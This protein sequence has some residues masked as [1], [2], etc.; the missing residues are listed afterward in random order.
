MRWILQA[1]AVILGFATTVSIAASSQNFVGRWEISAKEFGQDSFFIPINEGRLS[2]AFKDSR[3]TGTYNQLRFTGDLQKDGLHLNCSD[4]GAACGE[5][6]LNIANDQLTG[7]GTI[8]GLPVTV[9]GRRPADRPYNAPKHY[10]FEPKEFQS[11]FSNAIPPVLYIFPGD[12]VQTKTVDNRGQDE[13]GDPRSPRGNPQTGPFYVEGA[14]PGDTLVVH[15]D[16][17]RTNRNSAFQTNSVWADALESGYLQ[18]MPKAANGSNL[19]KLDDTSGTA[20]LSQPSD[21]LKNFVIRMEPMLGCIGVA[22]P[23]DQ[24]WGTSYLGVWG[25]NMDSREVREGSTLY[26]PVFQPGALLYLGDAHAQQGDGEITGQGL[27]TSMDVRFTVNVIENTS[28]GQPWI[29]DKDYIMVMGIGQ[30]LDDALKS[31]TTGMA[32]W[33][34]D[35]YQLSPTDLAAVMGTALQYEVAEVVDPEFNVVAKIRKGQLAQIR[36]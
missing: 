36:K 7:S 4:G 30:S 2:I 25:G 5:L 29:E 33:L 24:V 15:L 26:L 32:T 17:V 20:S 27:E 19:W 34:R 13:H 23:R 10:D 22:P 8:I 12:S 11:L 35:N 21:K 31:A 18:R 6:V 28:L 14:M 1:V 9:K 16:R 3:Y